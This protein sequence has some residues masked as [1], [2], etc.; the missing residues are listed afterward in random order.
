MIIIMKKIIKILKFVMHK[1]IFLTNAKIVKF[2]PNV[3]SL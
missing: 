2:F 1:K 3:E